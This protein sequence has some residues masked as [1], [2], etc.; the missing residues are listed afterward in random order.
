MA[1]Q[2]ETPQP[3]AP[4]EE[5]GTIVK[6]AEIKAM[7]AIIKAIEGLPKEA[8]PRV[9]RYLADRLELPQPQTAP[10]S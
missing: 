10:Q 7:V 4:K 3:D 5:A 6:D 1:K 8:R 2:P 9:S